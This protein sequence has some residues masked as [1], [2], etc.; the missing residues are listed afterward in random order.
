MGPGAPDRRDFALYEG[1]ALL[2]ATGLYSMVSF[3]V[4]QRTQE[5]HWGHRSNPAISAN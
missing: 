2:A 3:A 1:I 4:T 5:W